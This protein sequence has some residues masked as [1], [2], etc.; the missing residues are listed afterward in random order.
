MTFKTQADIFLKGIQNRRRNPARAATVKAY[1]S[2]LNGHILP[3]IGEKE[4]SEVENGTLKA[5]VVELVKSELKPA[6]ITSIVSVVKQV[7]GSAVDENGNQLF[8]R[9]WNNDFLDLPIIKAT[10]QD[11]P[12]VPV[13]KLQEA[14]RRAQG[15][16]KALYALLAGT[17]LRIGECLSLMVGPDDGRNSFWQ[18]ETGILTIRT[19]LTGGKIQPAPKTEAG[20][21]QVDLDPRLNDFLLSHCETTPGLLFKSEIGGTVRT[22]TAYEH[23]RNAGI[24]EG[25][26]A[27]RRFRITHLD[28]VGVPPGLQRF[29]TGHAAG[30]VH[31]TYIRMGEKIE[32]RKTW[33][34]KA[35]LGF[36]LEA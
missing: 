32:E 25:F 7:V 27:F 34:A 21:R 28:T 10:E 33:A 13:K 35:G 12:I 14:L 23:L 15:Q 5:L 2:F 8:P 24:K 3:L 26:H 16:D 17:G 18:P 1:R 36:Q 22:N 6:S 20:I 31:E 9:V 4:V 19:T 29:W 11:A 30:D